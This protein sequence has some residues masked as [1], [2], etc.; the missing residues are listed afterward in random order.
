MDQGYVTAFAALAGAALGN[1]T[2][3]ASSWTTLH[4]QLRA[5][6]YA[7][8]KSRRQELYKDFIEEASRMYGDALIHD[9]LE[10]SGLIN[11]YALIS[12]MRVLS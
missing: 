8:S 9:K 2:S 7:S 12:R 4:A 6:E 10:I 5:A 1:L 11:L 3:F